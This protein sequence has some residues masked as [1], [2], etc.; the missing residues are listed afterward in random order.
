MR[1]YSK[2]NRSISRLIVRGN[3]NFL[4]FELRNKL[5]YRIKFFASNPENFE[6]FVLLEDRREAEGSRSRFFLRKQALK[7]ICDAELGYDLTEIVDWE[8]NSFKL[9]DDSSYSDYFLF[10]LIELLIIFA[11]KETRGKI[12]AAL[13]G[14]FSEENNTYIIHDSF[15]TNRK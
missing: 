10:D 2:R 8:K 15:I 12:I 7:D 3:C 11:R 5:Q 1:L 9:S 6:R 14:I 4:D 13:N